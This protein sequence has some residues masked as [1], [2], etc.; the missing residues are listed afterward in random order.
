MIFVF[1]SCAA[2]ND[3]LCQVSKKR[4]EAIEHQMEIL[5]K[6]READRIGKKKAETIEKLLG[7]EQLA[8][9]ARL[10][11]RCSQ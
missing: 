10:N 5:V 1:L 8:E 9:R 7:D 6:L 3:S 11:K 4:V 2:V